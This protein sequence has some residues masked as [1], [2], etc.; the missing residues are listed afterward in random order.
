M[1]RQVELNQFLNQLK[2]QPE[3]IE[4]ADTI[5]IIDALYEFTPVAFSNGEAK[6]EANTNNGSCKI[7]AFGQA[8]SL[9]EQETLA[10]FG[11]F[12]RDDVLN[13][14][15]GNDHANIRNFMV[16]GWGGVAFTAQA[17]SEK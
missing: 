17:L 1:E 15:D 5:A 12:Y 8:Q 16:T 6:N 3:S 4:F 7:F 13:N 14:P 11:A 10:C 9:S 2:Q